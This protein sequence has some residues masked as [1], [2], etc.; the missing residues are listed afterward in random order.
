MAS[1]SAVIDSF[2]YDRYVN[3]WGKSP[4]TIDMIGAINLDEDIKKARSYDREENRKTLLG[5]PVAKTITFACQPLPDIEIM[6][7]I[8]AIATNLKQRKTIH[9]CV[10][11]HP[12]QSEWL[13]GH[14]S[15]YL[16]AEL[17][18][19]SRFTVLRNVSFAKVIS[20]TD[21][22]VSHFSNV[23]LMAPA[24]N[25]P[26][27]ALPSSAPMPSLTL[28]DMGLAIAAETLDDFGDKLDQILSNLQTDNKSL[29]PH[30]YLDKN[31]HMKTPDSL[32]RLTEIVRKGF[33]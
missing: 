12:S 33:N 7:A 27:I 20:V 8:H 15:E 17:E 13:L 3:D 14:I 9:L 31:P 5:S 2:A 26:V 24:F 30:P 1:R 22:L 16:M 4:E 18:D 11:L 10:K 19:K 23:C 29:P 25:V 32:K 28:A 6:A 21:I